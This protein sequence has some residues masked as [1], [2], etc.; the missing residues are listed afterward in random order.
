M[1][2]DERQCDQIIAR[3]R[4]ELE[5]QLPTDPEELRALTVELLERRQVLE[6]QLELERKKAAE[7]A[8]KAEKLRAFRKY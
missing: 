3:T 5:A 8:E 6:A 7:R 4:S 2:M 1:V